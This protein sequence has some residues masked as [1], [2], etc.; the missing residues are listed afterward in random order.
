MD[1]GNLLSSEATFSN[2][3]EITSNNQENQP[4]EVFCK[5]G[6]AKNFAE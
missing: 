2:L 5:K 3:Q 4:P 1:S 6:V